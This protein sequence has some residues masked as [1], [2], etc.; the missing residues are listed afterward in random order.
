[1]NT[2]SIDAIRVSQP[3]GEFYFGVMN[4]EDLLSITYSDVRKMKREV[5][6]YLGIQ[7]ELKK[8]R[9]R[10]INEYINTLDATFPNS[11]IVAVKGKYVSY[12]DGKLCLQYEDFEKERIAKVLDGQHRLAGFDE[13][14]TSFEAY[15][16][17]KQPFQ[18]LVTLF[19]EADISTQAK[20][21]AMVNQNQ[22]K[23]NP[24][25]VYDLESLSVSRSPDKTAH[26]I[27]V[28]LNK[29]NDS[30][31]Y[32]RIKRLGVKSIDSSG[33]PIEGEVLTQAAFVSNVVKLISPK[34]KE[35]R[36]LLL[37]KKKKFLSF[38]E[39]KFKYLDEKSLYRCVFRKS[40]IEEKDEVIALNIFEYFKAVEKLWPE[41]WKATNKKSVLNKT[42]GFI[43]L[44]R[45]LR[46]CINA[47]N[48]VFG[49]DSET[50]VSSEDFL[51]FM[52]STGID[53]HFFYS[54]D[55]VSKSSGEIYK[56]L[57]DNILIDY[58]LSDG[59]LNIDKI[60]KAMR[61]NS[62]TF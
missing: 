33:N 3:I 58:R 44:V 53:P 27:A 26:Q 56:A 8:S 31:F 35:D 12:S 62:K 43:A 5:E 41:E 51:F 29:K 21:F 50:V 28:L 57:S 15:D 14:N 19:V 17:E 4:A 48:E 39:K 32:K 36:N 60:K 52:Q 25:L 9:V 11:I 55:A 10:E 34:P 59:K 20:V 7:R 23:V 24:S 46:D 18:L 22:T 38:S 49:F 37:G 42:I 45:F 47:F 30:P 13:N 1:M 2:V 61:P 40:F 6:D 54:V 16:G